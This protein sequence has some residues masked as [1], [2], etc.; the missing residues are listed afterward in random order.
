MPGKTYGQN[1]WVERKIDRIFRNTV[2]GERLKVKTQCAGG[3]LKKF[4]C[5]V[6]LWEW[7]KKSVKLKT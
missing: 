3:S 2:Y 4:T 7:E 5:W 6:R 1:R